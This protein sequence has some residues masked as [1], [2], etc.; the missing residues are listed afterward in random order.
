MLTPGAY[1]VLGVTA[2]G[3]QLHGFSS[4]ME[5]EVQA[6]AVDLDGLEAGQVWEV[7]HWIGEEWSRLALSHMR[8][9]IRIAA[10]RREQVDVQL[11]ASSGGPPCGV[12]ALSM[13]RDG[14]E[15]RWSRRALTLPVRNGE[16]IALMGM[17]LLLP[18]SEGGEIAAGR[19]QL[20]AE[21]AGLD[22]AMGVN[23]P[24]WEAGDLCALTQ[25]CLPCSD[26]ELDCLPVHIS[27]VWASPLSSDE[28]AAFDGQEIQ[29][30]Q[31]DAQ[32]LPVLDCGC[33]TAAGFSSASLGWLALALVR[34]RRRKKQAQRAQDSGE[35]S[36]A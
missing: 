1:H 26:P 9:F 18:I 5:F 30:C 17:E 8:F 20:L 24:E 3:G 21:A 19:A 6:L 32:A 4:P 10:A 7:E 27:D 33:T 12:V 31:A 23:T 16:P 22:A 11:L 15:L 35:P 2:P 25:S 28:L 36:E 14:A 13:D 29:S 34:T